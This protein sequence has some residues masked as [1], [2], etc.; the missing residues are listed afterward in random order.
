MK[1]EL[2]RGVIVKSTGSWYDLRTADGT[3]I[4]S[5]IVGK[6]RLNGLKLTNPVAVGDHVEYVLEEDKSTGL[7]KKILPRQNY[8]VR[9][10][11][12]K[13]H[14]LHLLA[15]NIDQAIIINTIVEPNLKQGFIDRFLLMTEPH[16]VPSIIVFN[17]L[18]LWSE[19]EFNI[20]GG[21]KA[22][23]SSIGYKVLAIS[24]LTGE[25]ISEL[26]NALEGKTSLISGHSGVGKSSIIN[27]LLPGIELKTQEISDYTGKGTHTTTFAE[28]YDVDKT[29][30]IIDTPGIKSLAFN[31]LEVM[32]VIHNFKEFF[33]YSDACKFGDCSH[34]EEPKCAVKEALAEG[35]I[36][37]LR[38]MNYIT[39]LQEIEDQNYWERHKDM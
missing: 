39:I 4:S 34:R 7:I 31:N 5:R 14:H 25:N 16:N 23:Y 38:Y 20:F 30:H 17:K 2:E 12:R 22:I 13:K 37:E 33:E 24:A 11:P 6:F 26:K 3:V 28:M 29:S 9:Q 18:D 15:S 36:S 19:E 8:I 27:T 32:D 10:S 1:K 21:L 35:K